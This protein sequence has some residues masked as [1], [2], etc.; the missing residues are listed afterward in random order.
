[1]AALRDGIGPF[2]PTSP[3]RPTSTFDQTG[4]KRVIELLNIV[5]EYDRRWLASRAAR[6]IDS[7]EVIATLDGLVAENG[8]PVYLRVDHGPEFIAGVLADW[9]GE[10]GVE[11]LFTEP[12][13]P[14]MNG[15]IES[16]NGR[17]R[18][19]YLNGELFLDIPEAQAI[20][21]HARADYNAS[22]RSHGVRG[23]WHDV[24]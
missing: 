5:D 3:G 6:S 11:L 7:L 24:A 21:D 20:L 13:S 17:V 4:D 1:M 16:L 10:M 9:C 8:A 14:W 22:R 15:V 2:T 23:P 18:D 19:E 12:G